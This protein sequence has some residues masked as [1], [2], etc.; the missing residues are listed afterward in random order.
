MNEDRFLKNRREV[1]RKAVIWTSNEYNKK[2]LG[3][4]EPGN[5]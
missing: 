1:V 4:R 3:K 2:E 5:A